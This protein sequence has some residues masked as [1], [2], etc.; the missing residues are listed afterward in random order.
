MV[1]DREKLVNDVFAFSSNR[2][3]KPE[4]QGGLRG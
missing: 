3:L 2:G 1:P 4:S